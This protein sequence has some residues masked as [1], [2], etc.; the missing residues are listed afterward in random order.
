MEL[1]DDLIG[2]L[3][4]P[5]LHADLRLLLQ[6]RGIGRTHLPLHLGVFRQLQLFKALKLCDPMNTRTHTQQ[7]NET[8]L[9][10]DIKCSCQLL[11]DYVR[12][13]RH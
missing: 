5:L 12:D 10:I 4:Q 11:N 1:L 2:G 7:N 3:G 6:V 9:L 8:D 13:K